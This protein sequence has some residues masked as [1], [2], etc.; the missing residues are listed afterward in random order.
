MIDINHAAVLHW[1][2]FIIW[3]V[4]TYRRVPVLMFQLFCAID[5]SVRFYFCLPIVYRSS[6]QQNVAPYVP[7]PT[8]TN[9]FTS[10]C[11]PVHLVCNSDTENIS[12]QRTKS[13]LFGWGGERVETVSGMDCKVSQFIMLQSGDFQLKVVIFIVDYSSV[14]D[15]DY[16][17]RIRI[18]FRILN[19]F[20][21]LFLT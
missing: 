18:L 15:L 4:I 9:P 6:Q 14:L 8:G 13:G 3:R 11:V 7:F 17:F 19:W 21:L 1:E 20:F 12:F 2:K 16:F 10:F 5:S